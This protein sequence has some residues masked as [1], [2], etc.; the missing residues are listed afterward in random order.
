MS[1][2]PAET[3]SVKV[4]NMT[5]RVT[6]TQ[7]WPDDWDHHYEAGERVQQLLDVS[8]IPLKAAEVEDKVPYTME[9]LDTALTDILGEEQVT[10]LNRPTLVKEAAQ[11]CFFERRIDEASRIVHAALTDLKND[12]AF[13]YADE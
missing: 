9:D 13:Y 11:Q 10:M 1:K 2:A 4:I 8:G 7:D 3:E 5:L 12:G 6:I